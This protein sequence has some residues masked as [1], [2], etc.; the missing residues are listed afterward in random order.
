VE[1]ENSPAVTLHLHGGCGWY[2][3]PLVKNTFIPSSPAD[4]S[5]TKPPLRIL[6]TRRSHSTPR[7]SKDLGLL[8]WMLAYLHHRLMSVRSF[9]IQA[10]SKNLSPIMGMPLP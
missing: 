5:Q 2:K 10:F 7:F 6:L 4:R 9:S 1:F 3:R 8:L